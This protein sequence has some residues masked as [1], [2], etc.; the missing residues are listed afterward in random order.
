MADGDGVR[1]MR[2][3]GIRDLMP[4][5]RALY[6]R[7]GGYKRAADQM[8]LLFERFKEGAESAAHEVFKGFN[9]TKHGESRIEHCVKYDLS[10]FCRLV[11]IQ[12]HGVC[13]LCF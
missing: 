12:D 10:Q 7:G 11:T 1:T 4:Q 3:F 6:Q 9:R 8:L 5:V 2:F 13:L